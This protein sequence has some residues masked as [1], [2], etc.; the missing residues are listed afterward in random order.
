MDA[1]Y[2]LRFRCAH[3][4]IVTSVALNPPQLVSSRVRTVAVASVPVLH[5]VQ[6]TKP[7]TAW[8]ADGSLLT[9]V[10]A[11]LLGRWTARNFDGVAYGCY[12]AAGS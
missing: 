2:P 12:V 7:T 1:P 9:T 3:G 6:G 4:S 8:R 10:R 5:G 11:G